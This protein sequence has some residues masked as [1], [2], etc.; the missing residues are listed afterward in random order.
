MRLVVS[1]NSVAGSRGWKCRRPRHWRAHIQR[2]HPH[3]IVVLAI[4]HSARDTYERLLAQGVPMEAKS[5]Q[6]GLR[7]EQPQEMVN[8]HKYGRPEYESLL[9][10]ADYTLTARGSP[11]LYTFCMC[12]GGW[13]IPSVSEPEMF[14]TNGMSNSRHD[15]PFANSGL[16]VTLDP[17][18]F[19]SDHPSGVWRYNA[20]GRRSLIGW[21]GAL[22]TPRYNWRRTSYA[23]NG[24][25]PARRSPV[26][27]DAARSLW[28]STRCCPRWRRRRSARDCRSWTTNGVVIF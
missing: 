9:G 16:V 22:T 14:C 28:R 7:I 6:M 25:L 2:L 15:T 26:R 1:T 20:S 13:I 3:H 12:A 4:G 17:S 27:I 5:F 18:V 21:A 10:A 23:E 11:D 24:P 8:R 19:E